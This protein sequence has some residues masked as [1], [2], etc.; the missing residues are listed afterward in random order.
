MYHSPT[1]SIIKQAGPI[2]TRGKNVYDPTLLIQREAMFLEKM[3]GARAPILLDKGLDWIEIDYCGT[4]L[5]SSNIPQ[6]WPEQIR[7]ISEIL[8]TNNILHRDIKQGNLLVRDDVLIL[9]DFGWAIW[10]DEIPYISPRELNSNVPREMIYNNSIA[11][12]SL[13]RELIGK[14]NE[15]CS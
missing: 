3:K 7:S 5:N 14:S 15:I 9:I 8:A 1:G 12:H 2:F 11:L 13:L 10:S 4:D 6:N